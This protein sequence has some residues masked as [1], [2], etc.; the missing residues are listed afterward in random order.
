MRRG[1]IV[2]VVVVLAG[3][4]QKRHPIGV[5]R[6]PPAQQATPNPAPPPGR[7]PPPADVPIDPA[8]QMP[9]ESLSTRAQ[10]ELARPVLVVVD[11]RSDIFS[12]GLPAADP[13][14]G[15][16]LPA[17]LGLVAGGGYITFNKVTGVVGCMAAA[18]TPPDG[19]N[20]A[21]GNTNIRPANGI[22][23]IVNHDHSQFL[24][25][26]FLTP[27]VSRTAPPTLDFS[28][29]AKSEAFPELAPQIGQT[30]FIGDGFTPTGLQQRFII[31]T[32]ATRLYL[33]FAD[34]AAFQGEPGSYEDNTG[35][36]HVT[37]MQQQ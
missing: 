11:G 5:S 3:C 15:G 35:G 14:R 20:C 16:R 22:S 37:L 27:D 12:S 21:G 23:G 7:E 2:F 24:V 6:P 9:A 26:V 36:L 28:S 10:L 29:N 31:P 17:L 8:R 34:A 32:G 30:F 18:T 1:T 25:G 19:G 4:L 33:A 13:N